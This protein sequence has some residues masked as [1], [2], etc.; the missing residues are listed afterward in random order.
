M[1]PL[2]LESVA[3]GGM[4]GAGGLMG[5]ESEAPSAANAGSGGPFTSGGI[6]FGKG[7]DTT[8]ILI[9]GAIALAALF[10]FKR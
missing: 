1:L 7:I 4:F 8:M 2:V 6:S 3:Q 9:V 10:I 5:G